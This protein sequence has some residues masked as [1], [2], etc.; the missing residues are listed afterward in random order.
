MR[1]ITATP[2]ARARLLDGAKREPASASTSKATLDTITTRNRR[3]HDRS[4][5]RLH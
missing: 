3:V 5:S 2:A 1:I 4:L